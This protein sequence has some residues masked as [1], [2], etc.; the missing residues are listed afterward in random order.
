MEFPYLSQTPTGQ[1][2]PRSS[3]QVSSPSSGGLFQ[4]GSLP[5]QPTRSLEVSKSVPVLSEQSSPIIQIKVKA[6]DQKQTPYQETVETPASSTLR[7]L[8]IFI[9]K[10]FPY[11]P[12]KFLFRLHNATRS[13]SVE[14]EKVY[15][16]GSLPKHEVFIV[17][18]I[19][20]P[21]KQES[22]AKKFV[23]AC[24]SIGDNKPRAKSGSNTPNSSSFHQQQHFQLPSP[25]QQI[26][27]S[28]GRMMAVLKAKLDI[29]ASQLQNSIFGSTAL[30]GG[31]HNSNV[32]QRERPR[33]AGQME[34]PTNY[35]TVPTAMTA[36]AIGKR[37]VRPKE[38]NRD[39]IGA[40]SLR[41]QRE[42]QSP[43]RQW[44]APPTSSTHWSK[45]RRDQ[46]QVQGGSVSY[47]ASHLNSSL[48]MP[49]DQLS[50]SLRSA[51]R[52]VS[53]QFTLDVC[54]IVHHH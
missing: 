9:I 28:H 21:A 4:T 12:T 41:F 1:R 2:R 50:P 52:V 36:E 27:H 5:K 45:S 53:I 26:E 49:E 42:A 13:L 32:S 22:A 39:M 10:T 33:T 47:S 48:L 34:H 14:E 54:T 31:C 7:S 29:N 15:L 44:S 35:R 8:R 24:K 37:V 11:F 51:L 25:S 38:I 43:V 18:H 30:E 20:A 40:F 16:V 17:R 6:Y 19:P 3:S 46:D 23:T